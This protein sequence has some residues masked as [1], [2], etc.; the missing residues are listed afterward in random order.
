MWFWPKGSDW[1]NAGFGRGLCESCLGKEFAYLHFFPSL[2]Q[3]TWPSFVSLPVLLCFGRR[4]GQGCS[5]ERSVISAGYGAEP[6][7]MKMDG[8]GACFHAGL[9]E[10]S[11]LGKQH[12]KGT[13]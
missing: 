5:Q 12:T 11:A 2:I 7:A 1:E 10:S 3:R 8:D 6:M 9:E 4:S 13:G